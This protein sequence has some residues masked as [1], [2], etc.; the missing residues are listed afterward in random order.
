MAVTTADNVA[1]YILSRLADGRSMDTIKLLRMLYLCQGWHL[2]SGRGVLFSDEIFVGPKG[3]GLELSRR[4]RED[5]VSLEISAAWGT[6]HNL[7]EDQIATVDFV[8]D[9]YGPRWWEDV[10]EECMAPGTSWD[11]VNTSGS[12]EDEIPVSLMK[13]YF[14]DKFLKA[15]A[16]LEQAQI[17]AQNAAVRNFRV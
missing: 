17:R 5:G 15:Q 14:R 2:G 13:V 16:D 11:Q 8:V 6:Q 9:Q 1:R 7:T 4:F 3:P 10:V 12:V